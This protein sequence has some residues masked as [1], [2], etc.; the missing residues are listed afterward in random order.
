MV[1]DPSWCL[2]GPAGKSANMGKQAE[3]RSH[4]PVSSSLADVICFWPAVLHS[5]IRQLLASK[6]GNRCPIHF[7]QPGRLYCEA[8]K[9]FALGKVLVA[10]ESF[11]YDAGNL[12]QPKMGRPQFQRLGIQWATIWS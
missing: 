11:E 9:V 5:D 1:G 6:Q 4:L 7:L 3:P 10:D 2:Q 12:A 8:S